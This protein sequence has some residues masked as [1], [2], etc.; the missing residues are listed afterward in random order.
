MPVLENVSTNCPKTPARAVKYLTNELEK[1]DAEN[2]ALQAQVSDLTKALGSV[3]LFNQTVEVPKEEKKDTKKKDKKSAPKPAITAYKF[4]CEDVKT[5]NGAD[6]KSG[7]ELQQEWKE[8]KGDA[9]K[10]YTDMAAEDKKRFD[11]E[12]A[13]HEALQKLYQ[14]REQEKT[15]S[16]AMALYEAHQ[17]AAKAMANKPDDGKKKKKTKDADAPKRAKSAYMYFCEAKRTEV[18]SKN[19]DKSPTEVMKILGEEW[20]KLSKGKGGKNG[21][22]KFDD[23]AEKDKARYEKE[24]AAYDAVK[25]EQVRASK[26]E[27][28]AQ[29]KIDLEEARKM[30]EMAEA[31]AATTESVVPSKGTKG[32]KEKDDKPK[33]PKKAATAYICFVAANREQIKSGMPPASTFAEISTEVGRQWKL[34]NDKQKAPYEAMASKDKERYEQEK[35]AMAV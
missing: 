7:K 10:K 33:G 13:E 28:E 31:E 14:Q 19:T 3:K 29:L 23:L 20:A 6:A 17:L 27:E 2:E 1:R 11:R 32:K 4:Y 25:E 15:Q 34:L 16:A 35:A 5:K 24:K 21:T 8:I 30:V 12:N 18:V 9:R 26:A 22:K